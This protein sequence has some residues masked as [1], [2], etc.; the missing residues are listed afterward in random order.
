MEYKTLADIR[1]ARTKARQT[2]G[3]ALANM[4]PGRGVVSA[5]GQLGGML[6]DQTM[7]AFIRA[8]SSTLITPPH[9]Q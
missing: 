9:I 8:I 1:A 5:M 7:G 6:T 4:T 3:N 2:Q